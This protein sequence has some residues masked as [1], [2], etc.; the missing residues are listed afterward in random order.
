MKTPITDAEEFVA[1]VGDWGIMNAI[2]AEIARRLELDRAALMEAI[3]D[4]CDPLA[5]RQKTH[6]KMLAALAAA[7]ANFP[8]E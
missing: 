8:T 2:P 7:L 1:D 3:A 6:E 5:C 4:Y